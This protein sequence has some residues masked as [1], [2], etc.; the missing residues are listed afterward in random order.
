[1]AFVLRRHDLLTIAA[2]SAVTGLVSWM[3]PTPGIPLD[4]KASVRNRVTL[5]D[6]EFATS[7]RGLDE[8]AGHRAK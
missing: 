8:L 4:F 5:D 1:M 3:P 6:I 2:L 7:R